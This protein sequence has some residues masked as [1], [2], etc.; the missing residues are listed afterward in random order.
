MATLKK[1]KNYRFMQVKSI[2]KCSI[3]LPFVMKIFVL[4]IFEWLFNTGFTVQQMC[5]VCSTWF[6]VVIMSPLLTNKV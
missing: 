2:A 4:S 6:M 1:T 3:K 5:N